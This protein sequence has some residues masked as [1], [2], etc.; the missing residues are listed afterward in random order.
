[1]GEFLIIFVT[2]ASEQEGAEIGRVLVEEGLAACANIIP[3]I[4]SVY[5][6]K[7]EIWD[8]AETLIIIKST[9]E[10][11]ERIRSRVKELH[12]YEIPEISAIKLD[13]GDL[14]YLEWIKETTSSE[15]D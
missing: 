13:R 2:A 9:E 12:S 6:W 14:A 3:R 1:M 15:G 7:G 11:F 10:L 8:E 4:R 5:R